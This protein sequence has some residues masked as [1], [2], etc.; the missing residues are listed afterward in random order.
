METDLTAETDDDLASRWLYLPPIES[1]EV[2]HNHDDGNAHVQL[3]GNIRS[4]GL[5]EYRF[6]VIVRRS[7]EQTPLLLITAETSDALERE[8]PGQFALGLFRPNGHHTLAIAPEFGTFE[9]FAAA[10][11]KLIDELNVVGMCRGEQEA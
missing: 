11:G 7:G 9:G 1:L 4:V 2:L 3:C 10:A 5:I 8:N 6:M